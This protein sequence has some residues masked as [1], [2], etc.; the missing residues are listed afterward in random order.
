M[1]ERHLHLQ[2]GGRSAIGD[3][4]K[5]HPCHSRIRLDL[6]PWEGKGSEPND[7][8]EDIAVA[9]S[10]QT[11]DP[12]SLPNNINVGSG[13][14]QNTSECQLDTYCG[15]TDPTRHVA[16]VRTMQQ[17]DAFW[18]GKFEGCLPAP[19]RKEQADPRTKD[20]KKPNKESHSAP[21]TGGTQSQH[22]GNYLHSEDIEIKTPHD[23]ATMV[24]MILEGFTIMRV[25]VDTGSVFNLIHL[26]VLAQMGI[27]DKQIRKETIVL[28]GDGRKQLNI[29]EKC[30]PSNHLRG[31]FP[32]GYPCPNLSSM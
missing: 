10:V 6:L 2:R 13:S 9:D 27:G 30:G 29:W 24:E 4:Q 28:F 31:P 12:S 25:L 1:R 8:S 15:T 21:T 7:G 5:V 3:C 32:S 22:P 16:H 18:A 14:L 23:D 26:N 17:D 11:E 19:K 20:P